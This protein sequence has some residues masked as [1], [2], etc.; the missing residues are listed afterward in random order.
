M[1][2]QSKQELLEQLLTEFLEDM[3]RAAPGPDTIFRR[4]SSK[5]ALETKVWH[6]FHKLEAA[7]YHENRVR[8][9]SAETRR[10]LI[11]MVRGSGLPAEISYSESRMDIEDQRILFEIDAFFAASRVLQSD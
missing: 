5:T 6:F 10:T 4:T 8:Q 11:D 7:G 9:L 1:T 3:D 2:K